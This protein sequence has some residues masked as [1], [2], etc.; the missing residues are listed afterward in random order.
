MPSDEQKLADTQAWLIKAQRDLAMAELAL[1]HDE[2]FLDMAVYHC[3]QAAE[4]ALKG[5]LFGHNVPFRKTHNLVEL[6]DQCVVLNETL[7]TFKETRQRLTPF[8]AEFRYPGD[9]LEPP[10]EKMHRTRLRGREH[11]WTRLWSAC[12]TR[13]P[14]QR[15]GEARSTIILSSPC[16]C[17]SVMQMIP[18]A[19]ERG[20]N[21]AAHFG[22]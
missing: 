22:I 15:R 14:H 10:L 20:T 3:Q 17:A 13:L 2:P 6:L 16:L 8:A 19:P 9:L 21:A 7:N 1:T 5:F 11:C 12:Q 18:A 4:K